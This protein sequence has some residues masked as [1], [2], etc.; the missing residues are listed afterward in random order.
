MYSQIN[1]DCQS[2]KKVPHCD[3]C[4]YSK[5]CS[6]RT[7]IKKKEDGSN[8]I[9]HFG[10]GGV[11]TE[12]KNPETIA[13]LDNTVE[14]ISI[15]NN[16]TKVLSKALECNCLPFGLR[17]EAINLRC[18]AQTMMNRLQDPAYGDIWLCL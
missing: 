2:K 14:I 4:I 1:I 6:A 3:D 5:T 17:E 15:L 13:I 10:N 9:N 11:M 8:P 16:I 18:N 7:E 12:L